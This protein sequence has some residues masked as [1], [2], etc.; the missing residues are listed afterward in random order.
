M[1]DVS[2]Q[3]LIEQAAGGD[4]TAFARL[5]E[6]NYSLI[7]R[8]AYKWSANRQD[9]EDIAQDVCI[10][11][12]GAIRGFDGRARFSSWLYRI[13]LNAARDHRRSRQRHDRKTADLGVIAQQSH[14]PDVLDR[15][16]AAQVWSLVDRLPEKQRDAVLLVYGEALTH[17]QAG[18]IIECSEKTVSWHIH[19][20][21]KKL[22]R[23][24]NG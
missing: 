17:G 24:A 14:E 6:Q 12:G 23:L 2:Q 19:E 11:L 10:K 7:F 13:T 15:I 22:K 1:R 21:K 3:H 18:E 16:A 5:V 9:A 4:A 20:A 8:V